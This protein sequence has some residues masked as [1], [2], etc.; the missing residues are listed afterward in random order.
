MWNLEGYRVTGRTMHNEL[1]SGVVEMSRVAF[2]GIVKHYVKL[3]QPVRRRYRELPTEHIILTRAQLIE[4]N[5][6]V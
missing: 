2:G 4:I 1:V 6:A 5:P 3:D